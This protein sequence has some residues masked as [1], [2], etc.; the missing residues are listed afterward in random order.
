ML[1]DHSFRS[2]KR[3]GAAHLR[4]GAQAE[5]LAL[6]CGSASCINSAKR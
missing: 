5:E 3:A 1:K 6:H 2:G 4:G